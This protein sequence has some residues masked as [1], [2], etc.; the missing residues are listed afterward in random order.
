MR[1]VKGEKMKLKI[2]FCTSILTVFSSYSLSVPCKV[3][4]ANDY[5]ANNVSKVNLEIKEEG[6]IPL[7]ATVEMLDKN[8]LDY[9][10]LIASKKTENKWISDDGSNPQLSEYS[11]N[12]DR[13]SAPEG[14]HAYDFKVKVFNPFDINPET[15]KPKLKLE[16]NCRYFYYWM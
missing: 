14:L 15:Q 4:Q 9:K 13:F 12:V 11:V 3:L 10:T 16:A 2:V 6:R 8:V 5:F 1:L 7:K